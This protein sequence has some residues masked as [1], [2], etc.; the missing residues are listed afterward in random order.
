MWKGPVVEGSIFH[1]DEL[2]ESGF[3]YV[4]GLLSKVMIGIYGHPE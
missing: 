2:K 1:V 3:A 4:S